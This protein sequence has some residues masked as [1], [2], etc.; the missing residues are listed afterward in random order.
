MALPS[1]ELLDETAALI[2][3]ANCKFDNLPPDNKVQVLNIA[4]Q[5]NIHSELYDIS[6]DLRNVSDWFKHSKLFEGL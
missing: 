1:K 4:C 2:G 5:A 6:C 3:G